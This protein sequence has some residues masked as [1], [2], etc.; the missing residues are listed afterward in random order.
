LLGSDFKKESGQLYRL[1]LLNSALK[2]FNNEESSKRLSNI[3]T[4]LHHDI[5]SIELSDIQWNYLISDKYI[6]DIFSK[7]Q[8]DDDEE[9]IE[10]DINTKEYEEIKSV[11]KNKTNIKESTYGELFKIIIGDKNEDLMQEKDEEDIIKFIQF[12]NPLLRLIPDNKLSSEPEEFYKLIVNDRKITY[13]GSENFIDESIESGNNINEIIQFI[14]NIYRI[15]KVNIHNEVKKLIVKYRKF[16]NN[17][18]IDL[19]NKEY[20]LTDLIDLLFNDSDY[21][22]KN[23]LTILEHCFNQ[24]KENGSY[25]INEQNA[26]GKIR[27]LLDFDINNKSDEIFNLISSLITKEYYKNIF[28]NII[29]KKHELINE[30]PIKY[31]DLS[32]ECFNRDNCDDFSENFDYL[33]IIIENGENSQKKLILNILVKNLDNNKNIENTLETI[34][35]MDNMEEYDS[36]GLLLA[37]LKQYLE[38]N[39]ES[40]DDGMIERIKKI[41]KTMQEEN[42]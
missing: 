27:E 19:I 35:L 33:K 38:N 36:Y 1:K 5:T 24:K 4:N 42:I 30:L 26:E 6:T 15:S 28:N 16:L 2:Y 40:I 12:V 34:E 8:K 37:H 25:F 10:L 18:F 41:I 31:Q 39:D 17:E 29:N 22:N 23:T 20:S 3:V 7:M 9:Y 32:I 13:H 11:F 21:G 14:I